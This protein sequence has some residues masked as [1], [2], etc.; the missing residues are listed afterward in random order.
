ML[1][2]TTLITTTLIPLIPAVKD[3]PVEEFTELPSGLPRN[4]TQAT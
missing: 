3:A 2:T 4:Q 1:I